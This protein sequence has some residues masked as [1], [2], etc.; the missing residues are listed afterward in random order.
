MSSSKYCICISC[1]CVKRVIMC[2]KLKQKQKGVSPFFFGSKT[3]NSGPKLETGNKKEAY[4]PFLLFL[5]II[6][7][8]KSKRSKG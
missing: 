5:V 7:A 1:M 6:V 8:C 3:G 2:I 4:A